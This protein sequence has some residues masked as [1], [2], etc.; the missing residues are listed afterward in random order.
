MISDGRNGFIV[1]VLESERPNSFGSVEVGFSVFRNKHFE[2][3]VK[4]L[5]HGVAIGD[6][7]EGA[8]KDFGGREASHE[9]SKVGNT[10]APRG[11]IS[12]M[13]EMVKNAVR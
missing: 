7:V 5:W 12:D 2:S 10:I 4:S 3:V 6:P 13:S 9:I 1:G 11:R 8:L